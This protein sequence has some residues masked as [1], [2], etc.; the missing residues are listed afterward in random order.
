MR[1]INDLR[2]LLGDTARKT[3]KLIKPREKIMQFCCVCYLHR[4]K[5]I[6]SFRIISV[7]GLRCIAFCEGLLVNYGDNYEFRI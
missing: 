3:M 6:Y 7:Q 2:N 4:L 1:D 5:K